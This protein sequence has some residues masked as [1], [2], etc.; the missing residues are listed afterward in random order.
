MLHHKKVALVAGRFCVTSGLETEA[1]YIQKAHVEPEPYGT[2][3][4][5]LNTRK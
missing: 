2:A 3:L 5:M 4:Y 1:A